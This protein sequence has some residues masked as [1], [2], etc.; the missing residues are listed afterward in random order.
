MDVAAMQPSW[1]WDPMLERMRSHGSSSSSD[2]S[3]KSRMETRVRRTPRRQGQST[4]I[5]TP[6]KERKLQEYERKHYEPLPKERGA[7]RL[8][9]LMPSG[10]PDSEVHCEL[11]TPK[12]GQKE[13]QKYEALSWCWGTGGWNA[14]INIRSRGR[15]Y[16]KKVSPNLLAALK[17]LRFAD[18]DR[19]L[20]VDAICIN[21]DNLEEKNHQVEMMSEIYGNAEQVCVWLGQENKSSRRAI[22][23]I[24]EDVLKLQDFDTL[25]DSESK[26]KNWRAL[27]EL[28]QR[29]WF[30]RRWVV[31]EI[32]LAR[33]AFIHCGRDRIAWRDFAVAV[34]LFVEVETATHRLSEVMK[35][36]RRGDYIPGWFDYVSALGASLLVDA[37]E[38]LY[39]DYKEIGGPSTTVVSQTQ[40][41]D[42]DPDT[43]S[44]WSRDDDSIGPASQSSESNV[45]RDTSTI[46][47]SRVQPLLSLEYLV[48]SLTIFETTVPHDT[49]YA[50]LAIA[51]DTTPSAASTQFV[52]SKKHTR[53]GLELF[54]Q[55]KRYNV[56]Y[57]L[58]YVDVCKEFIDFAIK[59]AMRIDRSR[60]LDVICRPWATEEKKL[61]KPE[62][63]RR[64]NLLQY[65]DKG[66]KSN[67]KQQRGQAPGANP[68][69]TRVCAQC[70]KEG[71]NCTCSAVNGASG[72]AAKGKN[73]AVR[74]RQGTSEDMRMPSWIPQL[75]TAPFGMYEQAG[76]LGPKMS[77]RYADPLVG[78]PS[79]TQRN[80]SAAANKGVDMKSLKFRKRP[81]QGN[82]SMYVRGFCL[83]EVK[84]V[85]PVAQLGH[86]PKEWAE[87]GNWP[88]ARGD[89]PD[90]FWRTIVGDRG[91][92]GRNP[93]VYYSRA[94]RESFKKGGFESGAVDTTA[95]I[96][97]ER[98]SIVAQFCRR[99]Q[100]V[101]WNRV[102]IKTDGGRLGL[103]SKDVQPGDLVCILFGCSVPVILRRSPRKSPEQFNEELEWE[104]EYIKDKYVA[105]FRDYSGRKK[106]LQKRKNEYVADLCRQWRRE[107]ARAFFVAPKLRERANKVLAVASADF[108]KHGYKPKDVLRRLNGDLAK[109]VVDRVTAFKEWYARQYNKK[110]RE[111]W[112]A[113]E[114][115]HKTAE[116]SVDEAEDE[117]N[118]VDTNGTTP[119]DAEAATEVKEAANGVP[120]RA[121]MVQ[122]S[123]VDWWEFDLQI[124]Y[125]RRWRRLYRERNTRDLKDWWK[126]WKEER[127]EKEKEDFVQWVEK[128]GRQGRRAYADDEIV[129]SDDDI[130][131]GSVFLHLD[132]RMNTSV[133]LA[134]QMNSPHL[135]EEDTGAG[136]ELEEDHTNGLTR[137]DDVLITDAKPHQ[138]I[139][140][141]L[142]GTLKNGGDASS[143]AVETPGFE[144]MRDSL[145][146]L[147]SYAYRGSDNDDS[148][149]PN[150]PE[151]EQ[152]NGEFDSK[153]Y[154]AKI[155]KNLRDGLGE[156]GYYSYI[157]LGESYIHGMMDGEAMIYQHE[158]RK[159]AIPSQLFEI[160]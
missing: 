54:T 111:K 136:A 149:T 105:D 20:W 70:G 33:R 3:A 102:M 58:P 6:K 139:D 74:E 99:V 142:E 131:E 119:G 87:M 64:Q 148:P 27:L 133:T 71:K 120:E 5:A 129:E 81:K 134:D 143:P 50:L 127:K 117:V 65:Q 48:S 53:A 80:Y 11:I 63:K 88:D 22:R 26:S 34:E 67:E 14:A 101:I 113:M 122:P 128:D 153:E 17:A 47:K 12:F 147:D 157:M 93:P 98:N 145:G 123:G 86:I 69:E 108:R 42:S 140:E 32:A 10:A 60:A 38:R 72:E 110:K 4:T 13:L 151:E 49:I 35:R 95:L 109:M 52:E 25:C 79:L 85:A 107:N 75:T 121:S 94:C 89:P 114:E 83:D 66:S 28:M 9:N 154:E 156:D 103:V 62:A 1:A 126:K 135:A 130:R 68:K 118:G 152:G 21:Q 8:L 57:E 78:L 146:D 43:D 116:Q 31:Q 2:E 23:F 150:R 155:R 159:K 55:R 76:T 59:G 51:K 36:D 37:T 96:N 132:T 106:Q 29:P 92:D 115:A 158:G 100:S 18:R 46:P 82:F 45:W 73:Q 160:R 144:R 77:R 41:P 15:H 84:E 104:L 44:I 56:D 7:I 91:R 61:K 19:Y 90:A 125:G 97:Y 39:R 40:D 24:K 30:S 124:K 141:T 137:P 16:A 112:K 138:S